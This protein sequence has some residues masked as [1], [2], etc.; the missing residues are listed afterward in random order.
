MGQFTEQEIDELKEKHEAIRTVLIEY[1][2]EEYG[3]SVIDLHI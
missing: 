2:N 3:D 1:C